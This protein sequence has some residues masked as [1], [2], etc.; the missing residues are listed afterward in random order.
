MSGGV[1]WKDAIYIAGGELESKWS[2]KAWKFD[3]VQFNFSEIESM[4]TILEMPSL[5]TVNG[6]NN[7]KGF[8]IA[9]RSLED[10]GQG[11]IHFYYD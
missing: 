10:E 1:S 6:I 4:L 11:V 9:G 2:K 3:F 8:F 5:A 7:I